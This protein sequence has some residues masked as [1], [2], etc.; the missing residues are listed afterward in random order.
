MASQEQRILWLLQSAYP[1]WV[2]APSLCSISL[3]Y[4]ARLHSLRKQGWQIENRVE[5]VNGKKH[6][7]YRL[8][9]PLTLP[10]PRRSATAIPPALFD[11][12]RVTTRH[13]DDG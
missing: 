3:Q 7:A 13:R 4:C 11:D 12:S 8:A 6:G 5:T 10:N 2:P 9:A 1:N